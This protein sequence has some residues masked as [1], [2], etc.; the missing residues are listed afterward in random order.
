MQKM[1]IKDLQNAVEDWVNQFGGGYW[2]PHEILARLV[3]EVGE[4]GREINHLYG[5]KK[6]KET[7]ETR[8]LGDEIG[9]VI[10]TL[11]CLA[12]SKNIDLTEA[13]KGVIDKYTDR[14]GKRYKKEGDK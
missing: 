3:E 1:T 5:P 4:V 8:K 13:M 9:D 7:E 14:D 6:K 2:S 10:F 12:N 11:V